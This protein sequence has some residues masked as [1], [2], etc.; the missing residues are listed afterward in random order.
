M[1]LLSL[2]IDW[3]ATPAGIARTCQGQIATYERRITALKHA[4]APQRFANVTLPLENASADF[5]DSLALALFA[6]S[7]SSSDD[8]RAAGARC[9]AAIAT[10]RETVLQDSILYGNLQRARVSNTANSD[11]NRRLQQLWLERMKFAGAAITG[12]A[13]KEL[14]N[15]EYELAGLAQAAQ[16]EDVTKRESAI[17]ARIA[18]LHGF[19]TWTDYALSITMVQD[20][21]RVEKFL[22]ETSELVKPRAA[23]RGGERALQRYF[24][25]ADAQAAVID[26]FQELFGVQFSAD[27]SRA[28]AAVTGYTIADAATHTKL[29]NIYLTNQPVRGNVA[30]L[31]PRMVNGK[32]RPGVATIAQT[33]S[34]TVSFDD[35]SQMFASFGAAL[36]SLLAL[37]PYETLNVEPLADFANA[38]SLLYEDL[39]WHPEVMQRFGL[40]GDL[41][42]KLATAHATER[43]NQMSERLSAAAADLW[44]TGTLYAPLWAQ[45]YADDLLTAFGSVSLTD[46]ATGMR[47]RQ[48]VLAPAASLDPDTEVQNFLGRPMSPDA[49]YKEYTP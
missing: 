34:A 25:N 11:A 23:R 32:W 24:K 41:A 7:T 47:F 28:P 20:P 35:V 16:T 33:W 29:G 19:E 5:N 44:Q 26:V 14:A 9:Q 46:R 31:P 17:R 42:T 10:A 39:A 8:V 43:A 3:H 6:A 36:S 21:M 27:D 22:R 13:R 48:T 12:A 15:R 18:H 37:N 1:L 38:P 45:A 4:R 2:L 40:Q 30:L 49:F